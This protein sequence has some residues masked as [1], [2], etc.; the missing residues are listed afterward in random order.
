MEAENIQILFSTNKGSHLQELSKTTS[1]NLQNI[2]QE[3]A[4]I[5]FKELIKT[6]QIEEIA[7]ILS[8]IAV[9]EEA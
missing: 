1:E 8:E 5:L 2:K 4:I 9:T 6:D 7:Q 3:R